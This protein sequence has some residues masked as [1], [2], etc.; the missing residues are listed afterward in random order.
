MMKAALLLLVCSSFLV[1]S[2]ATAQPLVTGAGIVV[3]AQDIEP[4]L[5]RLPAEV[6][7]STFSRPAEVQNSLANLYVRRVLAAQALSTGID[8][9]PTVKVALELARERVLSEARLSQIDQTSKLSPQAIASYA[10]STYNA[11]PSRFESPE[12]IKVRHIL[13]R[14]T[15]PNARTQA[16]KLLLALQAGVNFE[17]LAKEQS[18]D[19]GS[20]AN[21]GDLGVVGK[22]R[23]VKSFEDAAFSLNK[24]GE[25]SD[26]VETKFGY[27]IIKLEQKLPKRIRGYDEVK[28]GLIKEIQANFVNSARLKEKDKILAEAYFDAEAIEAFAKA[29]VN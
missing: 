25:L 5:L 18:Q 26:I 2:S 12:Q 14:L 15:E 3:T 13:I 21:G 4:D 8:Q 28:D 22:G 29:Q 1:V 9:E 17:K 10:L 11:N 6:R 19:P 24:P 16:E 20:S 27:H 23:M 7:A